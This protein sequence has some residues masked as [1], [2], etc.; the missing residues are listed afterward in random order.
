MNRTGFISFMLLLIFATSL[1]SPRRTAAIEGKEFVPKFDNPALES[2]QIVAPQEYIRQRTDELFRLLEESPQTRQNA[3]GW[4]SAMKVSYGGI[5]HNHFQGILTGKRKLNSA[6]ALFNFRNEYDFGPHEERSLLFSTAHQLSSRFLLQTAVDLGL[7]R[8]P[9]PDPDYVD[10]Y[11]AIGTKGYRQSVAVYTRDFKRQRMIHSRLE[12]THTSYQ[13]KPNVD[14]AQNWKF[15]FS[16]IY[17]FFFLNNQPASLDFYFSGDRLKKSNKSYLRTWNQVNFSFNVNGPA[18][19]SLQAGFQLMGFSRYDNSFK[20]GFGPRFEIFKR[21]SKQIYGRASFLSRHVQPGFSEI[22]Y[23]KGL[24]DFAYNDQGEVKDGEINEPAWLRQQLT[25]VLSAEEKVSLYLEQKYRSQF[26]FWEDTDQ[27]QIPESHFTNQDML[28]AL[29]GLDIETRPAPH[30][31]QNLNFE[32]EKQ[33]HGD[34]IFPNISDIKLR[35]LLRINLSDISLLKFL[36]RYQSGSYKD[37]EKQEEIPDNLRMDFLFTQYVSKNFTLLVE[38]LNV[39]GTDYYNE[40]GL[41]ERIRRYRF[42]V[43]IVY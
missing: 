15:G 22:Y 1:S 14:S 12:L 21:F 35:G 23:Y 13:E 30:F 4:V 27:D 20:L 39:A 38:G 3:P 31:T 11:P 42:G 2:F 43:N 8:R 34:S 40:Y 41:N 17:Q 26:Y 37:R 33:F 32:I 24:G 36:F 7:Q 25:F 16:R 19:T 9:F 18:E 6:I 10:D 28:I 29:V 5:G